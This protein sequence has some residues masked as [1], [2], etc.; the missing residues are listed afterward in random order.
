[1]RLTMNRK[2]QKYLEY[3]KRVRSRGQIQKNLNKLDCAT[4][5]LKPKVKPIKLEKKEN[6]YALEYES[7]EWLRRRSLILD[8]D[9]HQCTSC[10]NKKRLDVHHLIYRFGFHV[11]EYED[12]WLITLCRK[13]H[14][15]THEEKPITEFYNR[16]PQLTKHILP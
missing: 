15:K 12:Q 1:M 7:P 5:Y 4:Y 6:K 11:W 2:R 3:R 8:R 14:T 10:G 16:G 13:C 9:N